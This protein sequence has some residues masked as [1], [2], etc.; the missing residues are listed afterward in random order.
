MI[1]LR[2]ENLKKTQNECRSGNTSPVQSSFRAKSR[3]DKPRQFTNNTRLASL[4]GDAP[5]DALNNELTLGLDMQYL[6]L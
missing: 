5:P 3:K 1:S 2:R 6:W 4:G